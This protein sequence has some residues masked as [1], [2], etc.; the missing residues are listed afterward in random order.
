MADEPFADDDARASSSPSGF[1]DPPEPEEIPWGQRFCDRP[2]FL[3]FLG[4]LI[5]V[6]FFTGWGLWEITS[7]PP[8]PLP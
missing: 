1:P 3:L 8:A 5:M 6:V 7:L 2:F 4:I